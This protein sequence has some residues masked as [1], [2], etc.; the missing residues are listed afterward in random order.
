MARFVVSS[1]IKHHQHASSDDAELSVCLLLLRLL[2]HI[3]CI[4]LLQPAHRTVEPIP[5]EL[6]KKYIIYCRENIK[7]K[8][9][10]IDQDKVARLYANLRKESM[11]NCGVSVCVLC[12]LYFAAYW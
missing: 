1:H 11:V 9:H 2:N 12:V 4:Q 7:P 10:Y 6:L 8:L 3:V 5:Q